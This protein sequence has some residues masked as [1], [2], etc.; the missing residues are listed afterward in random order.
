[1]NLPE[2]QPP[3]FDDSDYGLDYAQRQLARSQH[4]LRKLVKGFYLRNLLADVDG[5]AIDFGCGA[6]QVLELLPEGS[7]GLEAN[8]HLVNA[9]TKRGLNAQLYQPEV[10]QL[11]FR[12]LPSGHFKTLIMSH[13]LEHFEAAAQGLKTIFDSCN[14]LGIKRVIIVVP[15]QKGYSFDDTHRTFIDRAFIEQSLLTHYKNFTADSFSYF[16][17]NIAK[18]GDHFTFH[19]LKIVFRAG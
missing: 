4:P 13:V 2:P 1:M 14:R 7:V 10:D 18:I 17:I 19:E 6:G 5:P 16:P 11:S 12:E 15:G 8:S 3:N 9:L